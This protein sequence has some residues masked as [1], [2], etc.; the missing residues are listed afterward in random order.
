MDIQRHREEGRSQIRDP[1]PHQNS[2]ALSRSA[3]RE[4]TLQRALPKRPAVQPARLRHNGLPPPP[5]RGEPLE[6]AGNDQTS[7]GKACALRHRRDPE[8]RRDSFEP[9]PAL[10]DADP[11]VGDPGPH[12]LPPEWRG[13]VHGRQ[14][15]LRHWWVQRNGE[16]QFGGAV[17][18]DDQP[19]DIHRLHADPEV[20]P[21]VS[22]P[23]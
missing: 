19:L 18:P 6:T 4:A 20:V 23:R 21:V 13:R 15:H 11:R 22:P 17:R 5:Q 9:G 10:P 2:S 3:G 12:E 1:Q 7:E 8:A 16:G 14:L